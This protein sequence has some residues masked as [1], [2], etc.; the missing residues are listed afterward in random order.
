M[1]II[2]TLLVTHTVVQSIRSMTD[3]QLNN[4]DL[5]VVLNE[6]QGII[7]VIEIYPLGTFIYVQNFS[8]IRPKYFTLDQNDGPKQTDIAIEPHC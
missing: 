5:L 1:C 7:R 6:S 3:Q 2:K 8:E 4:L